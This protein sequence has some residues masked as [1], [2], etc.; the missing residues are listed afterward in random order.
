MPGQRRD[1]VLGVTRDYQV[2]QRRACVPI[3][4]DP[5]T[6]RERPPDD[7]EIRVEMREIPAIRR[8]FGYRRVGVIFERKPPNGPSTNA[9][10]LTA[11]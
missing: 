9:N 3:G 7:A 1:G 4:V 6:F 2:S 8:R 5:K 11:T 10:R